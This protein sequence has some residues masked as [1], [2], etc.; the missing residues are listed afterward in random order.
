MYSEQMAFIYLN[1]A[2]D[3]LAIYDALSLRGH[4]SY[5]VFDIN[6]EEVFRTLGTQDEAL[7][8]NAIQSN[9]VVD[10]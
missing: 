10:N 2:T 3:G 5:V 6:G 9:I 8:E 1:A 7:L 4:P